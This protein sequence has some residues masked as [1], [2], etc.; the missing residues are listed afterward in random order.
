MNQQSSELSTALPIKCETCRFWTEHDGNSKPW[1][2][3]GAIGSG[4]R[5]KFPAYL[6]GEFAT[7]TLHTLPHFYCSLW[8][9]LLADTECGNCHKPIYFNGSYAAWQHK[10]T[11]YGVC[12]LTSKGNV[13]ENARWAEPSR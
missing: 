1:G 2:S 13:R 10:E 8:A 12:H 9:E 11:G 5:D 7:E 6:T 3:C 4:S